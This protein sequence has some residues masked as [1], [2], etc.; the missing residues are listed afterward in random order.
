MILCR[1]FVLF[2]MYSF[3]GWIYE[4]CYCTLK[5]HGW[6]NRGFLYGPIVPIYGFGALGVT[7]VFHELPN[8]QLQNATLLQVFVICYLGS[9]VLEYTTS[10]A[11]EKIFHA[12]WWDYS[13]V[14]LNINGRVCVPASLGFGIA[15]IL[16]NTYVIPVIIAL[17]IFNYTFIIELLALI[18]MMIL[19]MDIALTVSA[20][21]TFAKEF[22]RLNTQFNTYM[23]EKYDN[24]YEALADKKAEFI[25]KKNASKEAAIVRK[26]IATEKLLDLKEQFTEEHLSN[27]IKNLSEIERGQLRHIVKFSHP[28][29]GTKSFMEKASNKLKKK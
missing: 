8:T 24:T 27:I 10:F 3:M 11:L 16:I 15:G 18:F 28:V 13:N 22:E 4:S 2:I 6:Q 20:L 23:S 5:D 1:Y 26:E 12:K 17:D 9:V 25:E 21:T 7:I 29:E 19:G 14:P